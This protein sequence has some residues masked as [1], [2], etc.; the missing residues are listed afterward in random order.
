LAG[1]RLQRAQSARAALVI[2]RAATAASWFNPVERMLWAAGFICHRSLR[3]A[4]KRGPERERLE[5][6]GFGVAD[7]QVRWRSRELPADFEITPR[8]ITIWYAGNGRLRGSVQLAARITG[9]A[10]ESIARRMRDRFGWRV[11]TVR[12]DAGRYAVVVGSTD[13]AAILRVVDPQLAAVPESTIRARVRLAP[14]DVSAL[15]DEIRT[16][17][18]YAD[19]ASRFGVSASCVGRIARGERRGGPAVHRRRSPRRIDRALAEVLLDDLIRGVSQRRI[20]AARG[21]SR[22]LVARLARHLRARS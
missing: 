8:L 18:T 5:V 21:V 6:C 4:S 2:T 3:S 13:V 15:L 7:L 9:S 17:A 14:D 19:L 12:V 20:A 10:A 11:R 1:A 22:K 16:G